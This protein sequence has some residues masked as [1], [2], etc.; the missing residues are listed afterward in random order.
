MLSDQTSEAP[1]KAEDQPRLGQPLLVY[2]GEHKC[3][4]KYRSFW[5]DYYKTRA[6]HPLNTAWI[7]GNLGSLGNAPTKKERLDNL[8]DMQAGG[9]DI[10][11]A[12]SLEAFIQEKKARQISPL[13]AKL[14]EMKKAGT[15]AENAT[16][17]TAVVQCSKVPRLMER[18]VG[19]SN[20]DSALSDAVGDRDRDDKL[21]GVDCLNSIDSK[22]NGSD[23]L[24]ALAMFRSDG[25]DG[26]V[27]G[28][29]VGSCKV[30][31]EVDIND[32]EIV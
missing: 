4:P 20:L 22:G 13:A 29:K 10:I 16:A 5:S 24:N 28:Q 11:D 21:D 9:K 8:V 12:R 23:E 30:V 14:K 17:S 27:R 7:Y 31:G 1:G 25:A 32:V 26:Q 15:A 19:E 2:D 3:F 6:R 18:S